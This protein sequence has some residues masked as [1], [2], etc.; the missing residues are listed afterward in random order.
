MALVQC[1]E[2]LEVYDFEGAEDGE[3]EALECRCGYFGPVDGE[4]D[5]DE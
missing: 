5:N 1:P 4:G 3:I 2:C